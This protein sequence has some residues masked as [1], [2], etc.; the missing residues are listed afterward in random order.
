MGIRRQYDGN[1]RFV[2]IHKDQ[3]KSGRICQSKSDTHD[4]LDFD[5]K[6]HRKEQ[7]THKR[8]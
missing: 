7:N 1:E 4:M 8:D 2:V 3:V 6:R 5:R